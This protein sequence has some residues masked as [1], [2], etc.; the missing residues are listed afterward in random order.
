MK[1]PQCKNDGFEATEDV[2]SPLMY[3]NKQAYDT[4]NYRQVVCLQCGCAFLTAETFE[5]LLK[6][7]KNVQ[8]DMFHQ[9]KTK[10]VA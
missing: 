6:V 1:C 2:R 4:V 9:S 7:K 8:M 10:K 5:R 3:R